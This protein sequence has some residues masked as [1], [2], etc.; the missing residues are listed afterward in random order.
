MDCERIAVR[1][2]EMDEV[3]RVSQ[4]HRGVA[5]RHPSVTSPLFGFAKAYSTFFQV[6]SGS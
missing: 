1:N 5:F 4:T 6:L 3:L 2:D